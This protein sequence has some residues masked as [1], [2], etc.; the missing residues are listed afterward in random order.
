MNWIKSCR[1]EE[2][3][4]LE[5]IR[6]N[7]NGWVKRDLLS[8]CNGDVAIGMNPITAFL[9]MEFDLLAWNEISMVAVLFSL[10]NC[11]R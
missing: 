5:E 10:L 3:R 8:Y 11:P 6:M 7:I 9:L 1:N 2:S 4:S